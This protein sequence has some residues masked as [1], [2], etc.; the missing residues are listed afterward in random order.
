MSIAPPRT[1]AARYCLIGLL[2]LLG[3]CG[4][5]E[6]RMPCST[7]RPTPHQ[8]SCDRIAVLQ[9]L[10]AIGIAIWQAIESRGGAAGRDPSPLWD[11]QKL[12]AGWE[13]LALP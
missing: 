2:R 11:N 9:A 12:P 3:V 4:G 13:T 7:D 8:R 6:R 5:R 10:H 1:T